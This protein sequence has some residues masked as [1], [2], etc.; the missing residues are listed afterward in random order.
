M[1]RHIVVAFRSVDKKPV[2][3]GDEPGEKFFEINANIGIGI[4]LD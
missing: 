4:F 1:R 2:S 3:V